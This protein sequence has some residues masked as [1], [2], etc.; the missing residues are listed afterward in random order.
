[1]REIKK[2]KL[3]RKKCQNYTYLA[4]VNKFNE[5]HFESTSFFFIQKEVAF[6]GKNLINTTDMKHIFQ[7]LLKHYH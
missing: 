3:T 4:L 6:K 1:M 7:E 5:L 2:S